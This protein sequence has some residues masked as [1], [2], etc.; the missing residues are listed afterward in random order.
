MT[1][2]Q[3]NTQTNLLEEN[4]MYPQTIVEPNISQLV[5]D[6]PQAHVETNILFTT[7]QR[8]ELDEMLRKY[9]NMD[10]EM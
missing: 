6:V 4:K 9:S 2:E 7:K 8:L 3:A 5:E 10:E 1:I